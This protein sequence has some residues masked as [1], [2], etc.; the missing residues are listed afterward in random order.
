LFNILGRERERNETK[1]IL[2]DPETSFGKP[3]LVGTGVPTSSV[4]DRYKA[5]E[6]VEELAA[7]YDLKCDEIEGAIR[8]ELGAA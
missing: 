3:V 7:D 2:I 6:S 8:C 1:A 5:G 4:A